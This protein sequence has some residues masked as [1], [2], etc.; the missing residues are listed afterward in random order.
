MGPHWSNIFEGEKDLEASLNRLKHWKGS[1]RR[2]LSRTKYLRFI[3]LLSDSL[4]KYDEHLKGSRCTLK[5][6]DFQGHF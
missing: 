3:F 4:N 5:K 2:S 6:L 1:G